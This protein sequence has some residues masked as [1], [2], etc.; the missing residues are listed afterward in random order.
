MA[1]IVRLQI[2]Y[3]ICNLIIIDEFIKIDEISKL[4][5]KEL[6]KLT[7]RCTGNQAGTD[8]VHLTPKTDISVKLTDS[9]VKQIVNKITNNNIPLCLE[10]PYSHTEYNDEKYWPKEKKN[11]TYKNKRVNLYIA[12]THSRKELADAASHQ[13]KMRELKCNLVIVFAVIFWLPALLF[14]IPFF[15]LLFFTIYTIVKNRPIDNPSILYAV[16]PNLQQIE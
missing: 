13:L 1:E 11:E 16:L 6:F 7:Y 4:L 3:E 12:V 2:N 10:I 5:N 15:I 8:N 9:L 14:V